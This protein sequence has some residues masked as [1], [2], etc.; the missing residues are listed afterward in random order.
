MRRLPVLV[1]VL[2]GFLSQLLYS[3]D[4]GHLTV[5]DYFLLLP[6]DTFEGTPSEWLKFTKQPDC[7][8]IDTANGYLSCTGDGAQP[9]FQVAL[10]RFSDGRPLLAVCSGELEAED[11][12]FLVFYELYRDNQMR[13]ASRKIFPIQDGGNRQFI[14]PKQGRIVTVKNVKTGKVLY[15]Y[16]WNGSTFERKG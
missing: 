12:L 2:C 1:F 4:Q 8:V 16:E 6:A 11:S 10:F 14:L 15:R 3:A 7:G 13:V 9:P 5:V